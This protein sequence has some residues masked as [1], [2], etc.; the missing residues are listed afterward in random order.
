VPEQCGAH[1]PGPGGLE[2]GVEGWREV[3]SAVADQ[4]L[5]VLE[6]LAE[7]EGKVAG[8]LHGPPPV[9]FAVTPPMRI[10]RV[11]CSMNNQHVYALQQHGVHVQGIDCDDLGGLGTQELPPAWARA[12]RRCPGERRMSHTVDGATVTPI[13]MGSPWIRRSPHS[14]FSLAR[15]M[16][17]GEQNLEWSAA[18]SVWGEPYFSIRVLF[19]CGSALG[20]APSLFWFA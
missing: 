16:L 12:P 5:N 7:A 15:W 17:T 11:P 1:D 6:P 18:L 14:G 3:Q 19:Y 2:D 10:R 8:L 20:Q 9:R 4:E 13:F